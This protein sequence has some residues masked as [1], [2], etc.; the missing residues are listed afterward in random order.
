MRLV[1][2]L[3]KWLIETPLGVYNA[4]NY[5]R[6]LMKLIDYVKYVPKKNKIFVAIVFKKI[7]S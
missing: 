6:R 4:A 3:N 7:I 1:P 2:K 5:K